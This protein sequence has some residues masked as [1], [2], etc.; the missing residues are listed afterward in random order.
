MTASA[1][2]PYEALCEM[3]EHE[4]ELVGEGRLD[5]VAALDDRRARLIEALPS[6]PPAA[7]RASLERCALLE[8]RVNIEL[9][10]AREA[11]MHELS[12]VARGQR[13]A[14]GYKPPN[15]ALPRVTAS[16]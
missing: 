14:S 10:R 5:E 15:L 13:A 4:L 3:A 9:L 8:R 2:A 1:V 6:Q 11:L 16:A 12:A 7:A